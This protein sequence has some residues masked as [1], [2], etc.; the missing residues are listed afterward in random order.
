L[1]FPFL[2]DPSVWLGSRS[3]LLPVRL[4]SSFPAPRLGFA[5]VF[6]LSG[7]ARSC[8]PL[9]CFGWLF[10][11]AARSPLPTS[12]RPPAREFE[13]RRDFLRPAQGLD[14]LPPIFPAM[15]FTRSSFCAT[16]ASSSLLVSRSSVLAHAAS[17]SFCTVMLHL[18]I[19]PVQLV[20]D[21]GR[22]LVGEN[23]SYS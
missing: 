8:S 10:S 2:S 21:C 1:S 4:R 22:I 15:Y 16:N 19:F 7:S 11:G 5:L 12:A 14:F 18:R 6:A 23:W 17:S 20:F 9:I 13:S 3:V